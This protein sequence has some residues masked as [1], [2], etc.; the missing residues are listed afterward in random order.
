MPKTQHARKA[1]AQRKAAV[2][3]AATAAGCKYRCPD[4][5]QKFQC[6]KSCLEHVRRRSH[7]GAEVGNA[8]LQQLCQP[9]R[10][11]IAGYASEPDEMHASEMVDMPHRRER[12]DAILCAA[13]VQEGGRGTSQERS[14]NNPDPECYWYVDKTPAVELISGDRSLVPAAV[15]WDEDA[16]AANERL[17]VVRKAKRAARKSVKAQVQGSESELQQ[18]WWESV[19]LPGDVSDQS[20]DADEQMLASLRHAVCEETGT[21]PPLRLRRRK[22]DCDGQTLAELPRRSGPPAPLD[23]TNKGYA[24]LTSL[25]WAPGDGLGASSSGELLPLA[26]TLPMQKGRMGLGGRDVH[27]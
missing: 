6:W 9:I 13:Q 7:A 17:V 23:E 27:L 15:P 22:R 11:L 3:A 4:C 10:Q 2:A 21:M 1:I 14:V 19:P 24:M 26:S 12:E 5:G 20:C 8:G 18:P 16:G 25:G